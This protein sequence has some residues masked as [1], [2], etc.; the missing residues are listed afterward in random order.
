WR[1]DGGADRMLADLT[2]DI[3]RGGIADLGHAQAVGRRL[4]LAD[5]GDRQAAVRW[6]FVNAMLAADYGL[7]TSRETA[8]ALARV[9]ATLPLQ[10]G[11]VGDISGIAA[12]GRAPDRL[13]AGGPGGAGRLAVE[14][15]AGARGPALPAR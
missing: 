12:S 5:P 13:H 3:D 2:A 9:G 1:R 6:A 10:A 14:G 8:D 15:A 4:A 11:A 7:E